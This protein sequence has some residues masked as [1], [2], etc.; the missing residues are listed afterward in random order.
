MGSRRRKAP[1]PSPALIAA[2]TWVRNRIYGL[3]DAEA[4]A[5]Y[6]QYRTAYRAML[7]TLTR[8]YDA[9]GN[10]LQR[11]RQDVLAQMERE[12]DA[13]YR[14]VFG[15]TMD[16]SERAFLQGAAG[17][18]WALDVGTNP[19]VRVIWPLLPAEAVRA[20]VLAPYQGTPW[21]EDLGYN[22]E[23]YKARI[24]RSITQSMIQG[25][26]MAKA[27]RR[28]RDELGI[29]TDRRK[30]FKRN[31]YRTLLI[32]RNEIMRASNLGALAVYEQNRDILSSWEWSATMDRATCPICGGLDGK[33]FRFD[34]GQPQ[35]PTG[36]HPGCRCTILPVLVDEALMDEVTGGPRKTYAEWAAENGID[37]DG[38]LAGQRGS[39]P[40]GLNTTSG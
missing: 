12:M 36:S 16:A 4:R 14:Q 30:G 1:E 35:P 33:R 22:F 34:S 32:A 2:E 11:A 29:Q 7:D 6:E 19:D 37:W 18:T 21:H 31:F 9:N 23:E 24:K 26:G 39:Q 5:L 20:A 13:L 3:S 28:L 8:A 38:G 17:S 10:P 25:E 40:H 27:Q 15:R